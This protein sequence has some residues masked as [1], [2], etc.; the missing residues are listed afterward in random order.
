MPDPSPKSNES[1]FQ[2]GDAVTAKAYVS[3]G[4][5]RYQFGTEDKPEVGIV[6]NITTNERGAWLTLRVSGE[7][8][9]CAAWMVALIPTA[10]PAPETPVVDVLPAEVAAPN[11]IDILQR[12]SELPKDDLALIQS[13][14]DRLN[15][16]PATKKREKRAAGDAIEGEG[17][18]YIETYY[19]P[20]TLKDGSKVRWGPYERE[21]QVTYMNGKRKKKI[22][23]YLGK[24]GA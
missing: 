1:Q 3:G 16:S 4:K 11:V 14:A 18:T 13:K 22:V 6:E 21:V 8:K 7:R 9:V 24:K 2:L 10:P 5:K 12:M 17:S 15:P 19:V 23:Q 20:G